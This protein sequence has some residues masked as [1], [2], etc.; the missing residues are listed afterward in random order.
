VSTAATLRDLARA[1]GLLPA[2]ARVDRGWGRESA[3]VRARHGWWLV[4]RSNLCAYLGATQEQ[5]EVTLRR[6]GAARRWL[7]GVQAD[8][9]ERWARSWARGE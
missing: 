4:Y 8:R 2:G 5:A 6:W 3:G 9:R 1:E 7:D